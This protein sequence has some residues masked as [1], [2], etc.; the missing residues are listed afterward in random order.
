MIEEIAQLEAGAMISIDEEVSKRF[1]THEDYVVGVVQEFNVESVTILVVELGN[2]CLVATDLH[3]DVNCAICE[4]LHEEID[5]LDEAD[6]FANEIEF[7]MGEAESTYHKRQAV[8][9]TDY[10]LPS[11]CEY[12]SQDDYKNFL[13]VRENAEDVILYHGIA[14][15]TEN[16]IL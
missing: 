10:E 16:V 4:E 7:R 13:L 15:E 5:Y 1:T 11:F 6:D 8:Y 3:G 14:V 9:S 12:T 2:Y